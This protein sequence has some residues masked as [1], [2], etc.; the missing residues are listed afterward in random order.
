[1]FV[2]LASKT[3]KEKKNKKINNKLTKFFMFRLANIT[4]QHDVYLQS[5]AKTLAENLFFRQ[6]FTKFYKSG[7]KIFAPS[8]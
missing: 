7:L 6:N 3:P 4:L 1:M 5:N 2:L 8:K